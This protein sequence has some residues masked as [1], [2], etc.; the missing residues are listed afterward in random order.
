MVGRAT[1]RDATR[2]GSWG[3]C[4]TAIAA[5]RAQQNAVAVGAAEQEEGEGEA[6]PQHGVQHHDRAVPD[7]PIGADERAAHRNCPAETTQSAPEGDERRDVPVERGARAAAA[8]GEH[9][10]SDRPCEHARRQ[11]DRPQE[12]PPVLRAAAASRASSC[13]SGRNAPKPSTSASAQKAPNVAYSAGD[14][15]RATT[16]R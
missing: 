15:A 3:R 8:R 12:R 10:E 6:H 7:Q 5:T 9:D 1:R 4:A 11:G 2:R 14:S 16:A 13:S